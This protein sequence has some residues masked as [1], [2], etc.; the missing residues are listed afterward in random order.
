M[1]YDNVSIGKYIELRLSAA[2]ENKAGTTG[3]DVQPA[4]GESGD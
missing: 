4:A 2:D 3:S 1:G